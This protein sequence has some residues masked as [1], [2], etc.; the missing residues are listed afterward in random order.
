MHVPRPHRR[1]ALVIVLAALALMLLVPAAASASPQALGAGKAVFTLDPFFATFV[2][3][4]FPVYPVAPAVLNFDGH[5]TPRLVMHVAG[6]TWDKAHSRGT[7]L[8]KGGLVFVHYTAGPVIHTLT[9]G[10]WRAGVN[11]AAGWTARIN[12]TRAVILDENLMGSHPSYPTIGG[13]KFVKVNTVILFYDSAF[14]T[15]FNTTFS[16]TLADGEPFGTATLLARLK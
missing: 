10:S 11:T 2:G 8:L 14:T 3:T 6:G 4:G 5:T 15:A 1:P 9:L 16:A 13:H 12:G 7:F